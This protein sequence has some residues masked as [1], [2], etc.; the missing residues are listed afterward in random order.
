V[1]P[2]QQDAQPAE[3][4]KDGVSAAARETG[5]HARR[6]RTSGQVSDAEATDAAL[7]AENPTAD[8]GLVLRINFSSIDVEAFKPSVLLG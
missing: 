1:A 5:R 6:S 8:D 3:P 2:S 7:G 4:P